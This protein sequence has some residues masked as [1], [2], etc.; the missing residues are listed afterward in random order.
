MKT[1]LI[2]VAVALVLI[3][4][5]F[6]NQDKEVDDSVYTID[7]SRVVAQNW[8]KQE[9]P[10]YT[11]DGENLSLQQETVVEEGSEYKFVFSFESR[12][13][14]YGDRTDLMTTQAI[15]PHEIR[16]VVL[17]N[18]VIEA[19]NDDVYDEIRDILVEDVEESD[20][21]TTSINVYFVKVNN[22][23]EEVVSVNRE[24]ENVAAIA[25]E[26]LKALIQGPSSEEINDG[27]STSINENVVIQRLEIENGI[28]YVDFNETLQENVAG[29]ATV[30]AIR[31]Q[32]EKTLMQFETVN[33][34]V[35]SIDGDVD[36]ILQ[37]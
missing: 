6:V 28:A 20:T 36:S 19:I 17:N 27:F 14:G 3:A 18:E 31:E 26:A 30:M 13:G 37:P 2:G 33:E 4:I 1:V 24:V 21:E 15:T 16:V 32:I 35:I 7:E 9:S 11:Y 5:F 22:G 12:S 25:R 34:V 23:Q 8:I 10:T 29:S